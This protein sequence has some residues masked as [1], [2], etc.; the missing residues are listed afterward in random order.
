MEHGGVDRSAGIDIDKT[1]DPHKFRVYHYWFFLRINF[2]FQP[3]VCDNCHD[4]LQKLWASMMSQLLMLEKI[5]AKFLGF[6]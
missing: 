2:K 3:C 1:S 5:I 6:E 4:L